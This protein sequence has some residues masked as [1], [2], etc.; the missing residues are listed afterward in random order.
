[1]LNTEKNLLFAFFSKTKNTWKIKTVGKVK[2][3][4]NFKTRNLSPWFDL[5][6]FSTTG[7]TNGRSDEHF[8]ALSTSKRSF[9]SDLVRCVALRVR[10]ALLCGD[11]RHHTAS[12][13]IVRTVRVNWA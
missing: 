13:G 1:M 3:W 11:T 10:I 2:A 9:T 4:C 8:L 6:R 7:Q 5:F 12:R